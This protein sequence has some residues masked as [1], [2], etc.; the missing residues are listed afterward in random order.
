M[1]PPLHAITNCVPPLIRSGL[2]RTTFPQG[3][4]SLK[5][6]GTFL[7]R[8]TVHPLSHT[9]RCD[10]SPDTLG[11]LLR[12]T[13]PVL[14]RKAFSLGRR[15]PESIDSGRMWGVASFRAVGKFV[16]APLHTRHGLRRATL[17]KQERALAQKYQLQ[18]M[19]CLPC[20][21][22]GVTEGDGGGVR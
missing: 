22:G 14:L 15:W 2:S 11:A 7:R 17:C 3:K 16:V 6:V 21:G 10:S 13:S 9:S 19:R 4:A 8:P 5:R 1:P 18:A 20:V 12:E